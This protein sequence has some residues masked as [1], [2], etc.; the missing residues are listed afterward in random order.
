MRMP[1]LPGRDNGSAS[2]APTFETQNVSLKR[3]RC[4]GPEVP[5]YRVPASVVMRVG[6]PRTWIISGLM[7][8][9]H[10]GVTTPLRY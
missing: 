2:V 5:G 10:N 4:L 8:G 3:T 9:M 7:I 1:N 6:M